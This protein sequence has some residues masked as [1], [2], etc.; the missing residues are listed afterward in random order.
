MAFIKVT[1]KEKCDVL[2]KEPHE[3]FET[4][5]SAVIQ[6]KEQTEITTND[7][8]K[9]VMLGNCT[10]T[11]VQKIATVLFGKKQQAIKKTTNCYIVGNKKEVV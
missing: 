4:F 8:C 5:V 1:I 11:E 6:Y 10:I 9:L 7:F 3:D 2:M